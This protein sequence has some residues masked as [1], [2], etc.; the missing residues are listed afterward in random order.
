MDEKLIWNDPQEIEKMWKECFT[1][2]HEWIEGY[3][4]NIFKRENNLIAKYDE[5]I[6]SSLMIEPYEMS[7]AGSTISTGYIMGAMTS[8]RYR[9]HGFMASLMKDTLNFA[10][11][12]NTTLLTLIPANEELY[13]FYDKFGFSTVFYVN[14]EHYTELHDFH[15][16]GNCHILENLSIDEMYGFFHRYE[17]NMDCRILHSKQDFENVL[18]DLGTDGGKVIAVGK[19]SELEGLAFTVPVDENKGIL[20]KE[21]CAL[22]DNIKP[23]ILEAVKLAYPGKPITLIDNVVNCDNI[24]KSRGMTRIIDCQALFTILAKT[25][26]AIDKSIKITDPL[27]SHNNHVFRLRGGECIIDDKEQVNAANVLDIKTLAGVLFN[28]PSTG[29]LFGL[30]SHRPSMSLMLD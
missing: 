10:N 2:N 22:N 23:S 14:E 21:L 3:F 26:P 1:D 19:D 17:L 8:P 9:N 15:P 24:I 12:R 5:T 7:Y 25:Y 6:V 28:T 16:S 11:S 4:H 29:E 13:F 27:L 20:I 30:R 18:W